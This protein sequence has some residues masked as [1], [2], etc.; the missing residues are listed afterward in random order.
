MPLEFTTGF[1]LVTYGILT[2]A[3]YIVYLA[4]RKLQENESK[5]SPNQS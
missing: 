3:W 4:K 5:E 2:E 1:L